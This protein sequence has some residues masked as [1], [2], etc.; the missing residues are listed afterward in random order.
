M[1]FQINIWALVSFLFFLRWSLTLTTRL[2]CSSV[3]SAHWY[4]HFPGSSDSPASASQVAG[5]TGVCH[6]TQ[7]I[8]I[9]LVEMR[10]HHVGQA[11]LEL[12]DNMVKPCLLKIQK[13]QPGMVV[14]ACNPSYLGGW[15]RRIARIWEAEVAV[16]WD[17]TTTLHPGWQS[18]TPSHK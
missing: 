2:E 14:D 12:L 5:I 6:H 11:G 13:N 10:F 17:G 3:I 18:K 9:P 15:G 16:S 1:L 7:L 8:F 4:L